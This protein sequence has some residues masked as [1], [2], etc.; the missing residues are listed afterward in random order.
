MTS[1]QTE[2]PKLTDEITKH[3]PVTQKIGRRRYSHCRN[4]DYL[5]NFLT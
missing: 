5:K 1:K 3:D 4:I 2:L